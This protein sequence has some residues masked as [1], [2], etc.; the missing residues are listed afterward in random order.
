VQI[1]PDINIIIEQMTVTSAL[2]SAGSYLL[3]KCQ[4]SPV[5]FRVVRHGSNFM[6]RQCL[7]SIK[8]IVYFQ[9]LHIGMVV[10]RRVSKSTGCR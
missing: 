1:Q 10:L 6:V 2:V 3:C 7:L 9:A 4:I 5:R 8:I